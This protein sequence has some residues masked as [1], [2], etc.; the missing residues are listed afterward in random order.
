MRKL[1]VFD[2]NGTVLADTV[3]SWKASNDCLEFFGAAPIS[4]ARF[5]ETVNF[6]VIHFYRLNNCDVD[7]VLARQAEAN[8]LFYA[9]YRRHAD[10]IRTRQ[11]VRGLLDFLAAQNIDRTILSNYMKPE[12]EEQ[13]IR[14]KIGHYFGYVCGNLDGQTVLQKTTKLDRISDFITKRG[15]EPRNV[16][17]IGDS[18]EE[19]EIARHLGARSISITG[20]YFS[21]RRLRA[22]KPDFLVHSHKDVVEILRAEC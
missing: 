3:A 10:K 9:S 14:L 19:P 7:D 15:Y 5:K 21:E 22:V 18:T 20:G 12:I 17:L 2:W 1:F 13:L 8:A 16:M 11:G 4:L 6:P